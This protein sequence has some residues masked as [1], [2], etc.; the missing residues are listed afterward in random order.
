[1]RTYRR[2]TEIL[3]DEFVAYPHDL[4]LKCPFCGDGY[5]HAGAPYVE[6]SPSD[7]GNNWWGRGQLIRIP[8]EGECGSEWD[9]C[10]GQHKGNE[11]IF[12]SLQKSC[13]R[14]A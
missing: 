9:L 10:I 7:Y 6:R 5:V 14:D 1:M 12:V 3:T 13:K 2:V 11:Y 8:F 4:M